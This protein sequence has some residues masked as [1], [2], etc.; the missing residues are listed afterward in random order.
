VFLCPTKN[1]KRCFVDHIARN[2]AH[3]DDS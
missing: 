3:L 2:H 1:G